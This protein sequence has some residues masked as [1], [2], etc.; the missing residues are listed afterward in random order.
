VRAGV[1][2]FRVGKWTGKPT[3]DGQRGNYRSLASSAYILALMLQTKMT[4]VPDRRRDKGQGL[5]PLRG[6]IPQAVLTYSLGP[7]WRVASNEN[8]A[9]GSAGP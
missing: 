5:L 1:A 6:P 7:L 9:E 4:Q 2:E 3:V 8:G